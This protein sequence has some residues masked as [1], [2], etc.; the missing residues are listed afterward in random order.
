MND[1]QKQK[2]NLELL[3]VNMRTMSSNLH[4]LSTDLVNMRS[5]NIISQN[6]SDSINK[7][8]SSVIDFFPSNITINELK[9][10]PYL[11]ILSE[12]AF[13][14]SISQHKTEDDVIDLIF[15]HVDKMDIADTAKSNLMNDPDFVSDN[16]TNL[17]RFRD[18]SEM[19]NAILTDAKELNRPWKGHNI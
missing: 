6:D 5:N 17:N 14:N 15:S 13:D 1:E 3:N 16:L 7:N 10:S 9:S 11:S 2:L 18:A 4:A 8:I 19:G 12:L